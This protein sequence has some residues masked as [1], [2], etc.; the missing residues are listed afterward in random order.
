MSG[1][2]TAPRPPAAGWVPLQLLTAFALVWLLPGLLAAVPWRL[3]WVDA[4]APDG[5]RAAWN[6]GATALACLG[7]VAFARWSLP[8]VPWRPMRFL[9]VLG[10][11]LPAAMV[12]L[13]LTIGYLQ[14]MHALGEPVPQQPGLQQVVALGRHDPRVVAFG[15]AIVVAAP[16]AEELLFRGYLLG[17]LE[18][19]FAPRIAD[20]VVAAVFGLVHGPDYALP[21]ALL[22]LLFGWLRRRH[23]SLGPS[24]CAHVLHNG[25]VFA[26]ALFAPSWLAW[27]YPR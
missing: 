6:M 25:L 18:L 14:G 1:D 9:A 11:Y 12:W 16:L 21:M 26:T 19:L 13:L 4:A 7:V 17:A 23:G 10:V 20:L 2:A 24:M 27:M 5:D 3:G 15:L 8:P 22:G